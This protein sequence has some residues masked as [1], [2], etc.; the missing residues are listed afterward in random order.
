[1]SIETVDFTNFLAA[2]GQL[3][4]SEWGEFS[5]EDR[6]KASVVGITLRMRESQRASECLISALNKIWGEA[7]VEAS[8]D[9][10]VTNMVN[11]EH[12]SAMPTG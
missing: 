2:G 4:L 7:Q 9:R 6:M 10:I 5:E 11:R 1:M 12:F 3:T 8:L